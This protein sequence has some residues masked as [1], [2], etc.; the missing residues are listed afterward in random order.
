MHFSVIPFA[1]HT[2]NLHH[3]QTVTHELHK[4]EQHVQTLSLELRYSYTHVWV[5]PPAGPS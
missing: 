3:N 5:V 2:T 4:R 1:T